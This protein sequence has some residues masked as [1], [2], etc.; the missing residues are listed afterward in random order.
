[1]QFDTDGESEDAVHEKAAVVAI[2]ERISELNST[3]YQEAFFDPELVPEYLKLL[4]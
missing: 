3:E 2:Q 4:E 1:M